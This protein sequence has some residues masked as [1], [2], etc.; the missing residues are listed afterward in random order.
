MA[1][2][3]QMNIAAGVTK[4]YAITG[5][6]MQCSA[7]ASSDGLCRIHLNSRRA[8]GPLNFDLDQL[9]IKQ[10][11]E[12]KQMKEERLAALERAAPV[13][14]N[15]TFQFY[16]RRGVILR[17]EHA[18]AEQELRVRFLAGPKELIEAQKVV[19][20]R[21]RVEHER[22]AAEIRRARDEALAR[23]MQDHE[24]FLAGLH[25][26]VA[27]PIQADAHH[28]W[29]G[30][31]GVVF[32]PAEPLAAPGQRG[33]GDIAR[34]PQSIHTT[35]VVKHTKEIVAKVRAI[36]VPEEYRWDKEICSKTPGE[37]ISECRLSQKAAHQMMSQYALDTSIYD[38]EEGIYGKVL[39]SMWQFVKGHAEKDSLKAIIR[40]E[41]TS[42][43]GMCAQGNLTRVCN[44]L[45]GYL[46]GVGA[47]ESLS[48][49]LGRLLPPLREI[50]SHEDRL[51]QATAILQE[52]EVPADQ[53]E[54]WLEAVMD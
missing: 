20:E 49:K 43:V 53:W 2:A 42:G 45:A 21:L 41:L 26:P 25:M 19:D 38:I 23:R 16:T 11:K 18:R 28:E 39:D 14:Y 37:I 54:T 51:L 34:D 22:R 35:E 27:M 12:V 9:H 44:I 33:L 10:K 8:N 50:E 36:P 5:K 24:R 4:C 47:K 1:A 3:I 30:G 52:N 13:D 17:G 15:A 7:N 48:D 40:D 31:E 32:A 46:D 29:A 6:G